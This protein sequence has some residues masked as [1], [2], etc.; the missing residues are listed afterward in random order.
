MKDEA[1]RTMQTKLLDGV[2]SHAAE[3]SLDTL[4]DLG[5]AMEKLAVSVNVLLILRLA[6]EMEGCEKHK[7]AT[8]PMALLEKCKASYCD[9]MDNNVRINCQVNGLAFGDE[10]S[11]FNQELVDSILKKVAD[12]ETPD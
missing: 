4:I 10:A 9:N 7:G 1:Y 3:A 5:M 6:H 11:P 12:E 2:L 8:T